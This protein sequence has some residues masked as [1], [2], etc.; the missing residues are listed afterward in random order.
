[1]GEWGE[2][3]AGSLR[4]REMTSTGA[5]SSVAPRWALAV[6]RREE[7]GPETGGAEVPIA[8]NLTPPSNITCQTYHVTTLGT[9]GSAGGG[10]KY[11]N[12]CLI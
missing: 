10:K 9:I 2:G 8:S 5:A 12:Q 3:W 6:T 1:M 4:N 7:D 11:Q